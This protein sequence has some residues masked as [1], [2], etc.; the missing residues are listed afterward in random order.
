MQA[1]RKNMHPNVAER[2]LAHLDSVTNR[3]ESAIRKIDSTHDGLPSVFV[4]VYHDWPE[5]GLITGFTF[6]LSA[7]DHPDWRFGRPELMISIE[8]TDEAWPLSVG[9]LAEQLRGTCPFCYGHTIRFNDKMSD[10]SDLDAFLIFGPPFLSK[11]QS[12]VDLGQYT[13][14]ITGMYPIY[15]EEIDLYSRI[16][17]EAFWHMEEWEPFNPNRKPM[18]GTA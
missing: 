13:C 8:S 14:H 2:Y 15:T 1:T 10:E 17:L 9:F 5:P 3:N 18:T 7:A 16:G 12:S 6:G 4:F 11:D